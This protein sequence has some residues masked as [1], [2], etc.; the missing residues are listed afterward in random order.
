MDDKFSVKFEN[1]F[2]EQT[3]KIRSFDG[4]STVENI[5]D[6]IDAKYLSDVEWIFAQMNAQ[7]QAAFKRFLPGDLNDE[8]EEII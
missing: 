7:K 3:V 8:F 4:M 2:F 5:Q 1:G 6:L